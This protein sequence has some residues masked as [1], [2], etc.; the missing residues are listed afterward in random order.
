MIGV[1]VRAILTAFAV[2][3][4]IAGALTLLLAVVIL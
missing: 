4:S 3:A 1:Q 2:T